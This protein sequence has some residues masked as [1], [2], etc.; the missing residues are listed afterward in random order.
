MTDHPSSDQ[1]F[2]QAILAHD[3][4]GLRQIYELFWPRIHA[5]IRKYGGQATDAEDVF[6]DAIMILYDKG[7]QPGF[8][9]TSSFYS[10][11][12]GICY[13]LW[14]N[15]L[16]KSSH[17]EVTLP[18]DATFTQDNNLE[19]L[20]EANERHKLFARAMQR[21]GDECRR[22]LELFFQGL[23]M[24]DIQQA[25]NFSS[26]AYAKKRKF[27]CKEKLVEQVKADPAFAELVKMD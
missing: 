4:A 14:S 7:R 22:L 15:Q 20:M 10:L 27:H 19:V 16:K 6:Q 11:L 17:R 24:K 18:E 13:R 2:L 25:M 12:Y 1:K 23:S 21:L 3:A 5:L 9:L 8:Q 26:E